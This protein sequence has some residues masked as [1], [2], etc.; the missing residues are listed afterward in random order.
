[1]RLEYFAGTVQPEE[2]G[3]GFEYFTQFND[4]EWKAG[5]QRHR[6]WDTVRQCGVGWFYTISKLHERIQKGE[7]V[8]FEVPKRALSEM[9][10]IIF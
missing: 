7:K 9:F 6:M 10:V 4:L 8:C 1:M 2:H 3:F 5:T